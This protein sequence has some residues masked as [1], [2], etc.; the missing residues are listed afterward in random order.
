[1]SV[2][3]STERLVALDFETAASYDHIVE[4]GCVEIEDGCLTGRFFHQMVRPVVPMGTF[5]S[6]IHGISNRHVAKMPKFVRVAE[7]FLD[8]IGSAQIVAHAEWVERNILQRELGRLG[9]P[10]FDRERFIC[11]L[12]MARQ[13]KRF[14]R[15]GLRDVCKELHISVQP[16]RLGY[17]DALADAHMAALVYLRLSSSLM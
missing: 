5:E 4:I 13:S 2:V 1:M 14:V 17:H 6:G 9:R 16:S 11:T 12:G 10:I 7:A 3:C 8:F 15:N